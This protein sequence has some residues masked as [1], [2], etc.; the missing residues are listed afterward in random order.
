PDPAHLR[1]DPLGRA[2]H[3]RGVLAEGRDRGNPEEVEVR[4]E[5][6]VAVRLEPGVDRGFGRDHR[7]MVAAARWRTASPGIT[8]PGR[9]PGVG[10]RVGVCGQAGCGA[11]ADGFGLA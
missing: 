6:L 8:T 11:G 7:P 2:D 3:V 1:G 10:V 4:R 9:W 5:A